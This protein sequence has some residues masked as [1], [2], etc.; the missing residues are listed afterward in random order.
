[1]NLTATLYL[2]IKVMQPLV[3]QLFLVFYGWLQT[4]SSEDYINIPD[5]NNIVSLY[6]KQQQP[7]SL[8]SH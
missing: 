7:D 8:Q 1:M 6:E 5:S 3:L 2:K 4:G